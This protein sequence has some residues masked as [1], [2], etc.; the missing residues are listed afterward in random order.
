[1]AN[2]FS[3]L[4]YHVVFSTKNRKYFIKP[5]IEE[6]VWSY[7]GGIAKDIGA[8]PLSIGGIEDHIHALLMAKPSH[9]PSSLMQKVKGKS[10][11]WI[12][13][14]MTSL[15]HFGWQD[16]YGVF[17]VSKS[18]VPDVIDYIE[19]QRQRRS[20]ISFEDEF[21]SMLTLHDLDDVDPRYI[22]G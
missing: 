5:D 9:S 6:R 3:S 13:S 19:N 11:K 4:F 2:T 12:N 21:R 22:F 17:S 16:G 18:N 15:P 14:E 10:S 7:L 20:G 1:M 8:E